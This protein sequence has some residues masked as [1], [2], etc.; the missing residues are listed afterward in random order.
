MNI[1]GAVRVYPRGVVRRPVW[2]FYLVQS[3]PSHDA[4]PAVFAKVINREKSAA[5]QCTPLHV[6]VVV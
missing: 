5:T 6:H 3:P 4:S 1:T 2:W